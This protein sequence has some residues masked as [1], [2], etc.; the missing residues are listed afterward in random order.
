M[1]VTYEGPYPAPEGL[2]VPPREFASVGVAVGMGQEHDHPGVRDGV[3]AAM[4]QAVRDAQAE[5]IENPDVI[6][7]RA[8][9][10]RDYALLSIRGEGTGLDIMAKAIEDAQT[11]GINDPAEIAACVLRAL[12][13]SQVAL[14]AR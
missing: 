3:L 4:T 9:I 8:L 12:Q 7:E 11:K 13:M 1:D 2:S 10:A 14:E 6:R 5:G